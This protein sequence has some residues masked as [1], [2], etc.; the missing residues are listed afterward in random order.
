MKKKCDECERYAVC[1]G[2]CQYHYRMPSQIN[3]NP[4][5]KATK[6]I[7]KFSTKKVSEL[8]VYRKERDKFLKDKYC[9]YPGCSSTHVVLHHAAGRI[10][11]L[12]TDVR[13]FRA[14]CDHHHRLIE[15]N[16]V[17]AKELNLSV[18]RLTA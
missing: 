15:E 13:Y 4:I 14:L 10:G 18:D 3:P 1:K 6:P 2:K 9:Q 16:P 7:A 17:H 5:A 8:V 12:L 11:S